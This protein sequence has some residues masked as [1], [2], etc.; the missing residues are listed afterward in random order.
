[1]FETV[2]FE[3]ELDET[4]PLFLIV[5]WNQVCEFFWGP[6]DIE[7]W[8]CEDP[9]CVPS[10]SDSMRIG[11]VSMCCTCLHPRFPSQLF[12]NFL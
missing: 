4:V 6:K 2:L 7:D 12:G 11:R 5:N 8:P 1:M 10:V 3:I 9:D